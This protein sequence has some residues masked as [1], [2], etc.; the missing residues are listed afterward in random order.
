M[1]QITGLLLKF[2][3][4]IFLLMGFAGLLFVVPFVTYQIVFPST[5]GKV[6]MLNVRQRMA[7]SE[8]YDEAQ[9]QVAQGKPAKL[10]LHAQTGIL[11]VQEPNAA[12]RI[13]LRLVNAEK[14]PLPLIVAGVVFTLLMAKILGEIKPDAPFTAANVRRLRWLALLLLGCEAYQRA[15]SWWMQD[16]L[17]GLPAAGT[18]QLMSN[19]DFGSSLISSGLAAAIL[20]LLASSYRRGVEL[21]EEAELTV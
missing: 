14:G 21:A 3:H 15:A 19:A 7:A 8:T 20:V 9:Q 6:V 13:L 18:A 16:Y 12:R 5:P 1:N 4:A 10:L 17:S 11:V 2:L